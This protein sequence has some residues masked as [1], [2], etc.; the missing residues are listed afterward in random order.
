ML[1]EVFQRFVQQ[2]PLSVMVRGTL[3]CVLGADQLD[4]FYDRTAQCQYTRELLFSTVYEIM[5]EV[6]FRHQPSVRAAYQ[7]RSHDIETSLTS[8]YNKLNGLE[9][10]TS[11]ELVR[12]S[13]TEFAPLIEQVGGDREP[14]LDGYRVKVIDGNCLEASHRRLGALRGLHAGALPGKSLVIYEPSYGLVTDVIPCEDGHAQER[15]LFRTALQSARDADLWIA[16]RNFC[17]RDFLGDLDHKGAFFHHPATPE[18]S[19]LRWFA[20]LG[21]NTRTET[22]SVAEQRIRFTDT[23]GQLHPCRRPAAQAQRV[24]PAMATDASRS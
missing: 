10:Q 8:V 6:V 20:R 4:Q 23:D 19:L 22:G 15:S 21:L 9:L 3:E 7:A 18:L 13:A 2:S 1:G 12:Y 16:D 14:W 11:A 5:S 17:T 24:R